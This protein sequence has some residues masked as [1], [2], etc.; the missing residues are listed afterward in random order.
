[1]NDTS[2]IFRWA[3]ITYDV[4]RIN[5]DIAVGKLRG[6]SVDVP[7]ATIE[8]F[9]SNILGFN[10]RR[11]RKFPS[12]PAISDE[13]VRSLNEPRLSEPVVAVKFPRLK[14]PDSEFAA[15]L[16]IPGELIYEAKANQLHY[17]QS[18]A[19]ADI[20]LIDGNHRL[21]AVYL[22]GGEIMRGLLLHEEQLSCYQ[23]W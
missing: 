15:G 20:V 23:Q 10:D 2:E 14:N 3:H 6:I 4:G 8:L 12:L 17:P 19:D 16:E 21:A 13:Y 1:M 5:R 18:D 9:G 7:R 22:R 11:T